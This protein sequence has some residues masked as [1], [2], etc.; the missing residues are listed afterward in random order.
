MSRVL[1]RSLS[2]AVGVRARASNARALRRGDHHDDGTVAAPFHR[3]GKP[4]KPVRLSRCVY[5]LLPTLYVP[6]AG[7]L[8]DVCPIFRVVFDIEGL[9]RVVFAGNR[10]CGS[11]SCAC[12]ALRCRCLHVCGRPLLRSSHFCFYNVEHILFLLSNSHASSC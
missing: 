10:V 2:R 3:L 8:L 7:R 9:F 1:A 4:S 11:V 5:F 6:C 12:V